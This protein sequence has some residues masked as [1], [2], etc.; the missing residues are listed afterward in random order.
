MHPNSWHL[1]WSFYIYFIYE[2]FAVCV[3][4]AYFACVTAA[5][6]IPVTGFTVNHGCELV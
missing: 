1:N 5:Y 3:M 4:L 2:S 6:A